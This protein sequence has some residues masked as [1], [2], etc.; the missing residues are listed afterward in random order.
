METISPVKALLDYFGKKDGQTTAEFAAEI[1]ALSDEER[2]ELA[3]GAAK[4][5]GKILDIDNK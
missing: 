3:R 2:I 1:K 4:M 5:L